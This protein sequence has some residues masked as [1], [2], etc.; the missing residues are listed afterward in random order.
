MPR[1]L[2]ILFLFLLPVGASGQ[3]KGIFGFPDR[4]M[5]SSRIGRASSRQV[6]LMPAP[7]TSIVVFPQSGTKAVSEEFA[8]FNYLIDN[9]LKQDART[10]SL[11]AFA[12][13]DTIDFLRAKILFSDR[14][15][16]QASSLFAK[17][18]FDSPFGAE[19]FFYRT[20]SLTSLGDYDGAS[21]LPAAFPEGGPY[22]E[23]AALQSAGL[24]LLKGEKEAW[25]RASSA[26]TFDDYALAESE[27]ILSEIAGNRFGA[28]GKRAGLAAMASAVIPGAGKVYAGRLGE[29]VAAFLTVGS[30]GT[31]TAENWKRH[32]V[33]DWRTI[34]AG[35]LC[36]TFYLG[37]IYGSYMSVSIEKE[38][39]TANENATIVYH[40]HLPLRTVFR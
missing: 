10:L 31:I 28:R 27:R 9:G 11:S 4:V 5:S 12:P 21:V 24:A 25:G 19:S 13:S 33:K 29:G 35:S 15:F 22:A 37:N 23:V 2:L 18:P 32:G 16:S 7:D 40:L 6:P 14:K 36:A 1:G 39:R 3:V 8:F 17:V 34:L 20:L 38:Q 30:L 26:F